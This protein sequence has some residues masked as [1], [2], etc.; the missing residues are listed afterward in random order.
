M[1]RPLLYYWFRMCGHSRRKAAART[2]KA[3]R[4]VERKAR[5]SA[6]VVVIAAD[7][8]DVLAEQ[9]RNYNAD[10]AASLSRRP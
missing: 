5:D 8:A 2:R 4:F 1:K 10:I 6:P 9:N 3:R 7:A